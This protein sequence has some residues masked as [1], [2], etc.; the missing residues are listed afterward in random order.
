VA[1]FTVGELSDGI[2][3]KATDVF[4]VLDPED[5]EIL[6]WSFSTI[7]LCGQTIQT[8]ITMFLM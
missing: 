7:Q 1:E 5:A 8:C 4:K 2:S 6:V 3:S